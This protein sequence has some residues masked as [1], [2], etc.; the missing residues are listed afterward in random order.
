MVDGCSLKEIWWK[1]D[2]SKPS[3]RDVFVGFH[4]VTQRDQLQ[5]ENLFSIPAV[6]LVAKRFMSFHHQK[7]IH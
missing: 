4:D 2:F 7:Y 6:A 5:Y 1:F 3:G